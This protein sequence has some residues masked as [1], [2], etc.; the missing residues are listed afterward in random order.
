M[1]ELGTTSIRMI[2]GQTGP[3]GRVTRVDE[4]VQGISLGRDTLATGEIGAATTEQC[5]RAIRSFR[6][7]LAEYGVAPADVRTVATSAVREAANRDRF[8][9]RILV[10]TGIEVEIVDQAEVSRLTYRA[11]Q[12]PLS[13]TPFFRTSDVLVVEVGGGSTETLLFRRGKVDSTHL[14]RLGSLRMRTQVGDDQIPRE[15]LLGFMRAEMV[16]ML[17]QV[18]YN[19]APLASPQMVLLGAEARFACAALGVK[20]DPNGLAELHLPTLKKLMQTYVGLSVDELA[21]Q[22]G[23]T[24]TEAET[25]G[26]ALLIAVTLAEGLKLKHVHVG[27][28]SLRTGILLEMATGE[29]WTADYRRQVINSAL[30]IARKYGVNLRHARHAARYGAGMIRELRR[31]F[32]ISARDEVVFEV[33]ALLHEIGQAIN[34]G[35]HHKHSYYMILNSDIF[36]LGPRD[37]ALAAL[38]ARYHRRAQPKP[39]HTEYMALNHADRITVSKLA[40]VLRVANALDRLHDRHPLTP[41]FRMTDDQFVIELTGEL[42]LAILQQR[43]NERSQLFADIY[44]K[45]VVLRRKGN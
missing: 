38:V 17:A 32:D 36:G 34:T 37:I 28:V 42:D 33:A 10:A 9:D 3:G 21:R 45:T 27:E 8:R 25:L 20:R 31:R 5:V 12:P 15:R 2:V 6:K 11:V 7:V 4:L 18:Q 13:A 26:P 24:Y 14:Y 22:E 39:S 44:G 29:H 41:A 19:L 43:V 23:L 40:A 1:I 35:S 30:V 16:Q